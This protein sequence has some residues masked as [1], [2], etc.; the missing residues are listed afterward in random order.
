MRRWFARK[1]A[2][3]LG[4]ALDDTRKKQ[5]PHVLKDEKATTDGLGRSRRNQTLSPHLKILN[6]FKYKMF[7]F[8]KR[9]ISFW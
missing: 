2:I 6:K 4:I 1:Q 9:K 8:L 5:R 7:K 3:L